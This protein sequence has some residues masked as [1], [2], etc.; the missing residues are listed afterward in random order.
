MA[1][2]YYKRIIAELMTID[3]VPS[4]WRAAVEAMLTEDEG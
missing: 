1:K 3:D 2:I 4:K